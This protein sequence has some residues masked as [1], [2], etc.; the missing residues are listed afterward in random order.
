MEFYKKVIMLLTDGEVDY[1]TI[2]LELAKEHPDLFVKYA[3]AREV[4]EWEREVIALVRQEKY[5]ESIRT[6]RNNAGYGLK[7]AKDIVDN[8]RERMGFRGWNGTGWIPNRIV[9]KDQLATLD[10]L[11]RASKKL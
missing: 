3:S 4:L 6:L 1:R 8:L 9:D 11:I 5:V 2:A 10:D 7:E